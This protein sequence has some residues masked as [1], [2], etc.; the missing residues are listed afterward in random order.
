MHAYGSSRRAA[1]ALVQ[2]TGLP[3]S[4]LVRA[5]SL[6]SVPPA[7]APL[8]GAFPPVGRLGHTSPPSLVLCAATTALLALSG[9]FACRACPDTVRT[10]AVRGVPCELAAWW[11]P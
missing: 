11:Q 6:P 9:S 4:G 10:S 5:K 7:D 1:A 3:W 8:D 2:S